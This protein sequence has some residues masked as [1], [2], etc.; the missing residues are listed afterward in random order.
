M[1]INKKSPGDR[2]GETARPAPSGWGETISL[3]AITLVAAFL[4]FYRLDQI[5]PG[6]QFDQAFYVFDALR[7]LQGQ[8]AIFFTAPGQSEPLYQYLVMPAVALFGPDTPLGIKITS[9]FLGLVTIPLIYLLTREMFRSVRPA[10]M[11]GGRIGLLAAAY[12]AISSWHIFYSRDGERLTILVLLATLTFFFLWRTL[13]KGRRRDAILTGLC[14]GLVLYTYPASRIVP[15][16][17]AIVMAFAAW[18]DRTHLRTYLGHFAVIVA[19]AALVFL[20]LGIHYVLH[21]DTF[22]SHAAQVSVFANQAGVESAPQTNPAQAVLNNAL[23]LLGMFVWKGDGGMI[24]NVPGRPIFDPLSGVLFLVG[25]VLFGNALLSRRAGAD[26]RR[27]AVVLAAWIGL[28]LVLSLFSDDAPNY[29]R[30]LV[31][32]PAVMII[33]AWGAA[34]IWERLTTPAA[35]RIGGTALAAL[36]VGS[37]LLLFHDYFISFA[38]MPGLYY[39]FDGDKAEI[40]NWINANAEAHRIFLAPLFYQQGTISLLTHTTRLKSFDS[41]DTVVLPANSGQPCANCG[42]DAIFAFPSEQEKRV[43]TM[44]A[45]LGAL[46]TREELHG[47]KG[48]FL[49]WLYRIPA[50]NLPSLGNP[51]SGL[52]RGG[53]FVKPGKQDDATWNDNIRLLGHTISGTGPGQRNLAVT[54]FFQA[55]GPIAGNYTFSLKARPAARS[56]GSDGQER[57]WGQEDKFAGDNSYATP[58]WEVGDVVVEN[59]YPGLDA[60]APAGQ[61]SLTVEAYDPKS[62]QVLALSGSGE[63]A[64]KLGLAQ[65]GPSEGNRLQDLEPDRA[66]QVQV[67]EGLKLL[68]WNITPDQVTP[69]GELGLA[70]FWQ[71]AGDKKSTRP[72]SIALNDAAGQETNLASGDTPI[73]QAGRGICTWYDLEV[74]GQ[75]AVGIAHILVNGVEIDTVN[76][77]R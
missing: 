55:L 13:E 48:E 5:P 9:A 65:A 58:R 18:Q 44:A 51:L 63:T 76:M 11:G 38:E 62:G 73:P 52:A 74:P 23:L 30:V 8:F 14:A 59:F 54:L 43:E 49:L 67:A 72:V 46:G 40:A 27:R 10:A 45:R 15:I 39:A 17:V 42:Q 60:C 57:V 75:A 33:P 64:V 47:V 16:A 31:S 35:R 69:G 21:P 2:P 22:I 50:A 34:A 6:F 29:G 28:A 12:A 7:L 37:G 32:F 24:R 26:N 53:A 20:P 70:L 77:T 66:H 3:G 61:Y 4:R 41:R 19:V 1:G 56:G 25:L 36:V 71:G 68:G